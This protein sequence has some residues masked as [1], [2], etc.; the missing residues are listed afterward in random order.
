MTANAQHSSPADGISDDSGDADGS[1]PPPRRA[2]YRRT[3]QRRMC[4]FAVAVAARRASSSTTTSPLRSR[5]PRSRRAVG[6]RREDHGEGR[7]SRSSAGHAWTTTPRGGPGPPWKRS[8]DA[9]DQPSLP[10]WCRRLQIFSLL[11]L[12]LSGL[13]WPASDWASFPCLCAE[14]RRHSADL[15]IGAVSIRREASSQPNSTRPRRCP[16]VRSSTLH[17]CGA[18]RDRG[19]LPGSASGSTRGRARRRPGSPSR[20]CLARG[21]PTPTRGAEQNARARCHRS[22]CGGSCGE[23]ARAASIDGARCEPGC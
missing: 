22:R 2:R 8:A 12:S 13:P 18:P 16:G 4:R 9:A 7:A 5:R 3:R 14:P 21:S 1:D 17:V 11:S 6:A 10:M 23:G 20:R 19:L 15:G